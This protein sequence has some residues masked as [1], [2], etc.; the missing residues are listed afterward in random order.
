MAVFGW[1]EKRAISSEPAPSIR[2]K[3][4]ANTPEG[5]PR[6]LSE[7]LAHLRDTIL[8]LIWLNSFRLDG[9][10]VWGYEVNPVRNSSGA[11]FLTG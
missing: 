2:M 11:L 6:N 4:G 9:I 10:F 7:R 5:A 3:A 1:N 8:C